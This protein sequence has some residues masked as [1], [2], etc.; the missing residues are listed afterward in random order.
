MTYGLYPNQPTKINPQRSQNKSPAQSNCG[1]VM[2][3]PESATKLYLLFNIV[4]HRI[5]NAGRRQ[6]SI[7]N[8]SEPGGDKRHA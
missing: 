5:E 6:T 4:V 7:W 3:I 2:I 8:T 1:S